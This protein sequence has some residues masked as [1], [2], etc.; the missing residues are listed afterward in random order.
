VL[1]LAL[2][3]V[4]LDRLSVAAVKGLVLVEHGLDDVLAGGNVLEAADGVAPGAC[5]HHRGLAGLPAIDREA[6]DDL[7]AHC[8]V[9][10]VARLIARVR[11]EDQ[12]EAAIKALR[13]HIFWKRDGERLRGCCN[14]K[15][16]DE[17]KGYAL[18][19][20]QSTAWRGV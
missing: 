9:D 10:L 14:G 7:R 16:Q 8:V 3:H 17:G 18:H 11:G 2:V 12:Q 20:G 13:A 6:E 15:E 19:G 4:Q 5:V 1:A